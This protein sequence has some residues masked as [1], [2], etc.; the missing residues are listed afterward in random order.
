MGDI[1]E[2]PPPT[3]RGNW[4]RRDKSPSL[5]RNHTGSRRRFHVIPPNHDHVGQR[6]TIHK[7]TVLTGKLSLFRSISSTRCLHH[8]YSIKGDDCNQENSCCFMK[9]WI[10]LGSVFTFVFHCFF[11]VSPPSSRNPIIFVSISLSI[12]PHFFPLSSTSSPTHTRFIRVNR[13]IREHHF[14]VAS[15]VLSSFLSREVVR[16]LYLSPTLA[17][18]VLF[19]NY[20]LRVCYPR[21][22]L[23]PSILLLTIS[24]FQQHSLPYSYL[25]P[26]VTSSFFHPIHV[27]PSRSKPSSIPPFSYHSIFCDQFYS[28]FYNGLL[29]PSTPTFPPTPRSTPTF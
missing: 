13:R 19:I 26:L 11:P 25:L 6:G 4:D 28:L 10:T 12:L 17:D 27:S 5:P 15:Q 1:K 8:L 18:T 9:N 23:S 7:R 29:S 3:I 14:P 22:K 2:F 24:Q 20:R 21:S 16:I